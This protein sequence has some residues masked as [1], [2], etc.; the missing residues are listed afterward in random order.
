MVVLEPEYP[1]TKDQMLTGLHVGYDFMFGKFAVRLHGGAYLTDD[2]GKTPNYMRAG[3]RYDITD[4][5]F[6]QI[7]LKTKKHLVQIG[8]K[9]ALVSGHLNGDDYSILKVT[10]GLKA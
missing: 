5:F 9:L 8:Q 7:A 2:K 4:W 6:A 1:D 10:T 3:F